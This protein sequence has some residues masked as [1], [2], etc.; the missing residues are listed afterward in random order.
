MT[1][2]TGGKTAGNKR[3]DSNAQPNQGPKMTSSVESL[4]DQQ[5]QQQRMS[6]D[7]PSISPCSIDLTK[8][9]SLVRSYLDRGHNETAIFWAD[10]VVSLSGGDPKDIYWL[11]YAL[12]QSGQ[13]HRAAHLIQSRDL[14]VTCLALRL[15][16]ARCFLAAKDWQ[17][18]VDVLQD[19]TQANE[20]SVLISSMDLDVGI[21]EILETPNNKLQSTASCLRGQ[22]FE[23][24]ENREVAADNYRMAI[25]QDVYNMEAFELL[26]SHH[27]LT[28][29][30]EA[31][32]LLRLP[33][34]EQC[35]SE[36]EREMVRFLYMQQ[37]KKYDK[38]GELI[39][40]TKL[41]QLDVN[42]DVIVSLAERHYYNCD[43]KEASRI[44][45]TVVKTDPF[46]SSCLPLQIAVMVETGKSNDLFQLAHKLVD[47][48]PGKA[49][50]WFA[51]GCY[52]M[53]VNK[54]ETARRFLNK[55]T[56]LDRVFGP[57]WIAFG[58]S[59]AAENE[60][61]QAMAAYFTASQVMRGCHLPVLYIGLEYGLTNNPKL[62]DRFF[63]QA[64]TIAPSDPF[65]LHEMGVIFYQ[66]GDFF[67]AHKYFKDAFD[68]VH[69]VSSD[70]SL[71][72][73]KWE[74]L[75]NNLGHVTRK[76]GKFDE[77]LEYHRR[78]L[79]LSPR[80]PSTLSAIGFVHM[81]KFEAS[82]AVN[83]FHKALGI[84]RD[85]TFSTTMLD[86]A[87][88]IL[89]ADLGPY[90]CENMAPPDEWPLSSTKHHSGQSLKGLKDEDAALFASLKTSRDSQ[91]HL[92][93]LMEDASTVS[94][95]LH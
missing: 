33:F 34:K 44:I 50:S 45:E 11:A 29:D 58:H 79:V 49:V 2:R 28:P 10:K 81:L 39:V 94:M 63:T 19:E 83:Y 32:L 84:R 26:V 14:L 64:L 55:A 82:Q 16:C 35:G 31:E 7:V 65:V 75:L 54:H 3:P 12:F 4:V 15:L 53:L 72:P 89:L 17:Q 22:A 62:A 56:S 48:Y 87:L 71:L 86:H 52:Y 93:S 43:I 80:N 92:S 21:D 69:E 74:P 42:L 46:H 85:D 61:D 70:V 6:V 59:F 51:V 73:E 1:M 37:L 66:N 76:L 60:H 27:M 18:V 38:P 41:K 88:E 68:K 20:D 8:F 78:A 24:M 47:I 25:M 57:A 13:F 90:D 67:A 36:E 91:D 77:A 30:E 40:P 23:A 9:R 95:D 5:Q